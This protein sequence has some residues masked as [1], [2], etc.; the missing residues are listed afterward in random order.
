MEERRPESMMIRSSI[1][2]SIK[3]IIEQDLGFAKCDCLDLACITF[4]WNEIQK[5]YSANAN[6]IE[7]MN[8]TNNTLGEGEYETL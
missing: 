7:S 2:R 3:Q 6:L 1:R 5:C 8:K 4:A